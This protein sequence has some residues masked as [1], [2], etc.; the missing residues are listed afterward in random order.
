MLTADEA[1]ERAANSKYSMGDLLFDVEH[2]VLKAANCGFDSCTYMLPSLNY[3]DRAML[4][5]LLEEKGY[6]VSLEYT[7][8]TKE[9]EDGNVQYKGFDYLL[10]IWG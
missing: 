3:I 1:K 8:N 5:H 10:L 4:M 9:T 2:S 7:T 6:S